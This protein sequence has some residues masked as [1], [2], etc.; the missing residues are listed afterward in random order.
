M[1]RELLTKC[2]I[3]VLVGLFFCSSDA[4]GLNLVKNGGFENDLLG[5]GPILGS[6]S[7]SSDAHSG[8]KAL[9][10]D[11]ADPLNSDWM[12]VVGGETY[13]LSSYVKLTEGSGNYMVTLAWLRQDFGL[14][15]YDNDW[16]GTNHPIEYTFHGGTFVAPENAAWCVIMLAASP[17]ATA[18]F[19]DIEFVAGVVFAAGKTLYDDFSGKFIDESKWFQLELVREVAAEKLA[20]KIRGRSYLNNTTFQKPSGI[21]AI[22]TDIT[23]VSTNMD[24]GIDSMSFATIYGVFYNSQSSGGVTGDVGAAVFI[25]D[26]GSGLEA[27]W[28]V[29]KS[30]DDDWTSEIIGSG[31]LIEP[32]T[33]DYNTPYTAKIEY[34]RWSTSGNGFQFTVAGASGVFVGPFRA[35]APVNSIK[36]LSTGINAPNGSGVG[37]ASALFD[38][39]YINNEETV[40]D[41]FSTAP[42]D[43]TKWIADEEVTEIANGKLRLN[44]QGFNNQ[45]QVTLKLVDYDAP[46]L[47]AKVRIESGSQLSPGASG[48]ARI[49]GFYYNDSRGPGSGQDYNKFEDDVLVQ[50]R[51]QL[52]SNGDLKAIARA[53]KSEDA[54][55]TIWTTLFDQY[56]TTPIQFDT[57]YVLSIGYADSQLIFKCND[58]TLSYAITTP[59]YSP[60]G[61]HRMLRSRVYLDP[62]ESGY[63]KAQF[64][65]V[66]IDSDYSGDGWETINGT[67]TFNGDPV[68]AMVLANGQYMFSSGEQ[69]GLS[70]GEYELCVPLDPNGEITLFAFVDGL[71]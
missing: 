31:T 11:G 47:E 17:G 42:L 49:Q 69:E 15:R 29:V 43:Q 28:E 45:S 19:D 61:E 24:T 14:I 22:Q 9:R 41:D 54:N 20:S 4:Y 62:G 46:Y 37:F 2:W 39:V 67:V 6:V 59:E 16:A 10:I 5:W 66:Y 13:T 48:I 57:D 1:K 71:A 40:Y 65:D 53:E 63:I 3:I 26:R 18:Y 23:V 25:R 60:F 7:I 21:N 51:L 70:T 27:F 33:L 36:S 50:V 52:D 35:R 68:N 30:L 44:R 12:A 34:D 32:G 56:F 38:N 64:D 58:E 8:L 55:Q